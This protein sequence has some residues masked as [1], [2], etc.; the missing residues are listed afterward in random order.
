MSTS[1]INQT[2]FFSRDALRE[3]DRISVDQYNIPSIVLMENAARGAAD[4]VLRKT[5]TDVK[6]I[7]CILCGSGNNGGD[8]YAVA[9]HLCN[10]GCAVR[11]LQCSDPK[12]KDA[13]TNASICIAMNI[14]ITRW[15]ESIKY[16]PSLLLDCMFGTGLD[17]N[18]QGD[19]AHIIH[20]CNA[21]QAPCIAL[22]IP[23]GMECDSGLVLGCCIEAIL[24]ITFVGMKLGFRHA[25]AM[26]F[27]GEII[28]VDIGCPQA[29]L[30]TYKTPLT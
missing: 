4:I 17:R 23:S 25:A 10:A 21:E 24:T 16:E 6:K 9:R 30:Q 7:V 14:P 27:L 26:K 1:S 18:I 5:N 13:I 22:D 29:L 12:S 19:Y 28:V 11:I 20:W 15:G 2:P 8:G 3:I